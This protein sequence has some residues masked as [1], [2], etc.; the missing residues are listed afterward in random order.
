M[1]PGF[2]PWVGRISWRRKWQP[3]PVF[4]P[5]KSHGQRSLVG[6]SPWGCKESD[7]TE[8]LHF[9][10]FVIVFLSRS[11]HLLISCYSL[12]PQWFWSSR[13]KKICHCF[14]FFPVYLLWSDGTGYHNLRFFNVE[15]QA[16]TAL[17][18]RLTSPFSV[19][20]PSFCF[21]YFVSISLFYFYFS[22]NSQIQ[23]ASFIVLKIQPFK[24]PYNTLKCSILPFWVINCI[25]VILFIFIFWLCSTVYGILVSW[26]GIKPVPP[27]L[28][29][30]S[31]N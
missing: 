24:A 28:E 29:A 22:H 11:K 10:R 19:F 23:N 14:H 6:Y 30:Q 20:V 13:K 18:Q 17:S 1:R 26:P 4:F 12:R 21:C 15:F 25:L 9:T 8:Q 7:T 2:N 3:I 5:G 27:T 16:N 31:L